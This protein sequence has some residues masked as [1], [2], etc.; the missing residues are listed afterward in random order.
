MNEGTIPDFA[1]TIELSKSSDETYAYMSMQLSSTSDTGAV[2]IDYISYKDG[3]YL[4]NNSDND[5]LP[6]TWELAYFNN[7]SQDEKDDTDGDGLPN[8]IEFTVGTNPTVKDTDEDGLSDG[9]EVNITGTCPKVKDTNNDVLIDREEVNR[10]PPTDPKLA[11]THGDGLTDLDELETFKTEPTKA[12]TD[13]DGFD[14]S[15]EI[16][17]GSNPKNAD[18]VPS[19]PTL[20]NVLISEFM[21]NNNDTL[22][23]SDEESSDWIE[24]WNPTDSD[25]SLDNHFLT[26]SATQPNKWALP[27]ITLA[28]N[29]FIVI[30]ASGKDRNDPEKELHTDFQL[31]SSCLLYTSPSPRDA[32]LSRM[33]SSA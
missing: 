18:S 10:V 24:L 13:E 19:F 29:Q 11:D 16:S 31:S 5:E 3:L 12:D 33:P 25:I 26:D 30:F 14:D 23:D 21:A 4:P 32:T 27:E 9:H 15:T 1:E 2:E 20:D 6:D 8:G 7:L 17:S 22:L 28:P